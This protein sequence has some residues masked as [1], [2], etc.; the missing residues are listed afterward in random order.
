MGSKQILMVDDIELNLVILNELLRDQDLKTVTARNGEE[1]VQLSKE[2][3]FNLI[4]MDVQMP[5]MNGLEATR[6]IREDRTNPNNNT[7]IIAISSN[8]ADS[9]KAVYLQSGMNAVLPKP[10]DTM[11]LF[12]VISGYLQTPL[13]DSQIAQGTEQ[14][15][16]N[17]QQLF[18]DIDNLLRIGRNN[19]AFVGMM[20]RSFRDSANE[21]VE[22]M[23]RALEAKDQATIA[24]QVHKLKFALHILRAGNLDE[25]IK[26]IE[27]NTL[28]NHTTVDPE[29][30]DRVNAFIAVIRELR[31]QAILLVDSEEWN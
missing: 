9:D 16:G 22:V 10:F 12:R 31:R 23:E 6:L 30:Y 2:I 3:K 5:V 17:N 21:I 29:L 15:T 20:L 1:A 26:W 28:N 13:S 8:T 25:E 19:R 11:V 24:G 18:I 27:N 7:P 14:V 4:L